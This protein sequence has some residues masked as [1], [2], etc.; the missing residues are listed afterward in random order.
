[1]SVISHL[2]IRPVLIAAMLCGA[3]PGCAVVSVAGAVVS[4]GASAVST[5]ASVTGS[6]VK[7]TVSAVTP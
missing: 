3:L 1:M 2:P 7:G 6:V 4:T 5:A